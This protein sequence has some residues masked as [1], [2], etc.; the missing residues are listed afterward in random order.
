MTRP[1]T[2]DTLPRYADT[3]IWSTDRLV[4][5][6]LEA[7]AD[8]IVTVGK[9]ASSITQAVDKTVERLNAGGRMIYV[10]AGTSGRIA[11]QDAT[12]LLPTYNWPLERAVVLMAG[13]TKALY[14]AVERAE[15]DVEAAERDLNAL[16]P[17]ETDIIIGIAASG[18]TPYTCR[19]LEIGNARGSLTIGVF[20][21]HACK[22]SKL[23]SHP[24]LLETGPEFVTG[25]T[26]M[27]AGTAQ[28]AALNTFSTSVMIRLG[29]VYRGQMIDMPA[30]NDKLTERCVRIVDRVCGCGPDSAKSAL[31]STDWNVKLAIVMIE[32][33][34][35]AAQAQS[36]LNDADGH[37]VTA[38]GK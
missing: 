2:E 22:M 18:N 1:T 6:I 23:S 37:L 25:S 17:G 12:E 33:K 9:A 11:A 7:Q 15:D 34:V 27:K 28:K 30:T 5:G 21:N 4:D 29:R 3:H 13:G 16:N 36:L 31:Q 32:K 20:N 19:C 8:A 24:I 14:A 35:N 26:R 10:G 38:L